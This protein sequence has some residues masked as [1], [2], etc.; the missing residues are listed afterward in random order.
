M[1]IK[2]LIKNGIALISPLRDSIHIKLK[3]EMI[4][5]LNVHIMSKQKFMLFPYIIP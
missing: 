5:H 3:I 1:N 4:G 2:N